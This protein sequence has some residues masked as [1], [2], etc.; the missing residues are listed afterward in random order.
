M[1]ESLP[2][3]DEAETKRLLVSVLAAGE[4]RSRNRAGLVALAAIVVVLPA[5]IRYTP[6]ATEMVIFGLLAA[7]FDLLLGYTGLL[8][9]AQAAFFGTGAY[10]AG[11]LLLHAN[12]SIWLAML[13]A[14][15]AGALL[16][17]II[18][19]FS[20]RRAGIYFVML[21]LAFNEVVYYLAYE[22]RAITGGEN[23]LRGFSRPDLGVPLIPWKASLQ[24]DMAYYYFVALIFLAGFWLLHRMV[25][26]PFGRVLQA[27]REN[28]VRATAIGYPVHVYKL[29]AFVVS[30]ALSGVGG[31][32]YA[33]LHRFVPLETLT[34]TTSGN[35]IM[36]GLL[37]GS[38]TLYG[39]LIGAALVVLLSEFVSLLWARWPLVLGASFVMAVLF[40]RGGIWSGL[41]RVAQLAEVS[42]RRTRR[43]EKA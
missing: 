3:R 7:A 9:F 33:G 2:W 27:I 1:A 34:L 5:L 35:I 6:L 26:S 16:A 25:R 31:A 39:P 17:A 24:S 14:A 15:A 12:A 10:A 29:T 4:V 42:V 41:S 37:G 20:S 40:F 8:S 23:G 22:A 28:E 19:F 43:T 18:G 32:L 30:G 13:A 38:G 36:M 11:L 21:T